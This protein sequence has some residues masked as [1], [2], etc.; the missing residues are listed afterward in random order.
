MCVLGM[1]HSLKSAKLYSW[2]PAGHC[3]LTLGQALCLDSGTGK[4]EEDTRPLLVYITGSFLKK[5]SSTN[6]FTTILSF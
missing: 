4:A 3:P 6:V 5:K 2:L 1:S